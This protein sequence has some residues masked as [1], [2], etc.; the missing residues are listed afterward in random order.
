MTEL[1]H[2][3]IGWLF[4]VAENTARKWPNRHR[5]FPPARRRPVEGHDW[6]H[7]YDRDA[8]IEWGVL[9]GRWDD[10]VDMPMPLRVGML[11]NGPGH[12]C[13]CC[14]STTTA[15]T[16]SPAELSDPPEA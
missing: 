3:E 10:V 2:R 15:A 5:G 12:G 13:P 1:N 16:P 8:V 11:G 7:V 6:E 4:G 14:E 9:T